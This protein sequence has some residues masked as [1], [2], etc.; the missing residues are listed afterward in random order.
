M[1]HYK[2]LI[3]HERYVIQWA[4]KYIPR[5]KYS[6]S[7]YCIAYHNILKVMAF[8]I[9]VYVWNNDWVLRMWFQNL[10]KSTFYIFRS[11]YNKYRKSTFFVAVFCH[12]RFFYHR[13]IFRAGVFCLK[14]SLIHRTPCPFS[15]GVQKNFFEIFLVKGWNFN[16]VCS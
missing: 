1:R 3:W 4:Q 7:L 9:F 13:T 16:L 2:A 12:R 15:W 14:R 8:W 10:K 5:R 6:I 11:C